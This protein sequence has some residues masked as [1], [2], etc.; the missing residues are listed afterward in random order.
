MLRCYVPCCSDRHRHHNSGVGG[1]VE[2]RGCMD[3][4]DTHVQEYVGLGA[5]GG[6]HGEG[7]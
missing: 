6:E 2:L 7:E 1:V 3:G 4:R 5:G